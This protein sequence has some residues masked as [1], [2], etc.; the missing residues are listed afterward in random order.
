RPD[1]R[2]VQAVQMALRPLRQAEP[3]GPE[4]APARRLYCRPQEGTLTVRNPMNRLRWL[5]LVLG[6]VCPA[7]ALGQAAPPYQ[8]HFPPEEFR[9]RWEKIFERIG[10]RAVA[11]VQGM[12]KVNG[13]IF[14]RQNNEFYYL[15][16]V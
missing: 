12:P 6:L 13:F 14:P 10:D 3:A 5:P 1:R 15:C 16:G 7:P 8:S 9:A 11:L 4:A 2:G